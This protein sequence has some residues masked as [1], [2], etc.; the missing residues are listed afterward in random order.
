MK[1]KGL[2]KGKPWMNI[3]GA[4]G[5]AICLLLVSVV[6]QFSSLTGNE[7]VEVRSRAM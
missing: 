7:E 5:T 3:L 4:I 2:M 6:M 1:G